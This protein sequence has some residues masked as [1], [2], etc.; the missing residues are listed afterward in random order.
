MKK[1]VFI[2]MA[3]LPAFTARSQMLMGIK[4]GF[5]ASKI[6]FSPYFDQ[7]NYFVRF[8]YKPGYSGGLVFQYFSEKKLGL[9]AELLYSQKGFITHYDD[10]L[11]NQ[12]ERDIDYLSL[13]VITHFYILQ[14]NTTPFLLLGTYGSLAIHSREIYYDNHAITR[15]VNYTFNSSRDNRWEFGILGGAGI[16]RIFP[17]G[18][19]QLQGE[20]SYSFTSLYKW[21]ARSDNTPLDAYFKIPETAESQVITISLS[22]LFTLKKV[23]FQKK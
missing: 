22:Y 20:F 16:K 17:F 21:G 8:N 3:C 2:L 4:A 1:L 18:T 12:Y 19:L 6:N 5:N 10:Q 11:N 9:Q 7:Y 23:T 14:K 15:E 13:P